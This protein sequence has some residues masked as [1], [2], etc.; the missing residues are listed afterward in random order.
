MI[1]VIKWGLMTL[2]EM[3]NAGFFLFVLNATRSSEPSLHV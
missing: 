3:G 2:D 1:K